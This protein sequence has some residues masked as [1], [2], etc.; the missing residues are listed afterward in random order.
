MTYPLLK[1]AHLIGL[2]LMSAGL[3]GVF[4]ADLRSRQLR[5]LPLFAEAI[6][7]I[8]VFYDGLLVPGAPLLLGSGV[9]LIVTAYGGWAF[10]KIPWLVGMV[11]L[12]GFEFIEGNTVTRLYFLK[13]RRLTKE[14][15]ESL[16]DARVGACQSRA[17][18]HLYPLPR[19]SHLTSHHLPRGHRQ[20]QRHQSPDD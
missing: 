12:F 1:L 13:L 11:A 17:R 4:V 15:L 6:R 5:D 2:A 14:S 3:I 20:H 7:S 8:A 19:H 18:P 10:L 9:W 16:C